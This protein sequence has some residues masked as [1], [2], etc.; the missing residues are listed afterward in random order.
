VDSSVVDAG[1]GALH[2]F[3]LIDSTRD[4]SATF[5]VETESP[6]DASTTENSAGSRRSN[7]NDLIRASATN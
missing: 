6:F 1:R 4:Q 7:F 2:Q 3:C 5:S